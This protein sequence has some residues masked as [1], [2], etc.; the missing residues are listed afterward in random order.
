[1]VLVNFA[2]K[3]HQNYELAWPR[4]GVWKIRFSAWPAYAVDGQEA[5][6]DDVTVKDGK[7][8]IVMPPSSVLIL[9]QD[10]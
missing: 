10:E 9:S 6:V 5:S 8:T 3:S 4:D 7:G 1:M 2:N